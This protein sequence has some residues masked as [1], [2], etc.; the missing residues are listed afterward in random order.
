[1]G[2]HDGKPVIPQ[3]TCT[4]IACH[5]E[6][7]G[8]EA[9]YLAGLLNASLF[10]EAAAAFAQPGGKSFGAPNLLRHI[11]VPRFDPGHSAHRALAGLV[12]EAG[13]S[14]DQAD[15]DRAAEAVWRC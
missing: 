3:E 14:L 6:G 15:L 9:S 11:A 1:V 7:A 13:A 10:N 12:R 2:P 8:D 5:G 4:F